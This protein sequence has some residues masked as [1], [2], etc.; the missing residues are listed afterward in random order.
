[1]RRIS[2][3]IKELAIWSVGGIVCAAMVGVIWDGTYDLKSVIN[4][5]RRVA[6]SSLM[7]SW[8]IVIVKSCFTWS[9][10]TNISSESE[11]SESSSSILVD[12][13][14]VESDVSDMSGE[15]SSISVMAESSETDDIPLIPPE[16]METEPEDNLLSEDIS[17]SMSSMSS[18]FSNSS[19]FSDDYSDDYNESDSYSDD[20]FISATPPDEEIRQPVRLDRNVGKERIELL[21]SREEEQPD[22]T[23]EE[24]M[25]KALK[26]MR[27]SEE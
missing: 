16:D 26:K 27:E 8:G 5:V 20:E 3:D 6:P 4:M 21:L 2:I 17:E 12:L 14:T 9:R 11:S 15:E 22:E 18:G 10:D 1:V 25:E 24:K 23:E 19:E 7:F 13:D